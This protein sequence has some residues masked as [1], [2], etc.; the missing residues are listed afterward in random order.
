MVNYLCLE[1]QKEIPHDTVKKRIRCPFCG[2]K[3]LYK[4]RVTSSTIDAVQKMEDE[5][6]QKNIAQL[7]ALEQNIQNVVMQK[8]TF[9]QQTVEIDNALDEISSSKGAV[10]KIIGNIMVST[11]KDH[12]SKELNSKKE[13][14]SLRIKSI[15]KQESQLKEK[16]SSLQSKVL[17]QIKTKGDD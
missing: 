8:Q 12:I 4:P 5:N 15:E 17:S 2:S 10:Y 16:A 9:Q 1:C 7:Q 6:T 11:E 13:I 14:I 3:I